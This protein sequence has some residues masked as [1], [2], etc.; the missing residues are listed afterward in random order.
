MKRQRLK[1]LE[2]R[3]CKWKFFAIHFDMRIHRYAVKKVGHSPSLHAPIHTLHI[4]VN[5]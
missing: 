1:T 5:L 4:K 3:K 2:N